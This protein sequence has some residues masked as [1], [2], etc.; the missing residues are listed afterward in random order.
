[1]F[2][3]M[4]EMKL[5]LEDSAKFR[6]ANLPLQYEVSQWLMCGSCLEVFPNYSLGELF[7]GMSFA[8]S[9]VNL[10]LLSEYKN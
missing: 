2:E 3:V 8:M 10:T 4:K 9:M 5:W 6:T 1:M 7:T